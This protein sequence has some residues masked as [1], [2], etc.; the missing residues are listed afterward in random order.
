[1]SPSPEKGGYLPVPTTTPN[2]KTGPI[3]LET[4]GSSIKSKKGHCSRTKKLAGLAVLAFLFVSFKHGLGFGGHHGLKGMW[5]GEFKEGWEMVRGG[6]GREHGHGFELEDEEDDVR[7]LSPPS[8][9]LSLLCADFS[10]SSTSDPTSTSLPPLPFSLLKETP[11]LSSPTTL[12][13]S[14]STLTTRLTLPSPSSTTPIFPRESLLRSTSRRSTPERSFL[15]PQMRRSS[16]TTRRMLLPCGFST[17]R[18]LPPVSSSFVHQ[19]F[20]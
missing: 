11:P 12:D 7:A 9:S 14:S 17:L 4:E 15:L 5:S 3:A 8:S 16:P 1:M 20:L 2:S 19:I 13:R 6:G 18:V 10:F